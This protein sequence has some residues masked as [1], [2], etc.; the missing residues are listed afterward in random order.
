[1]SPFTTLLC[2]RKSHALFRFFACG[3]GIL[4]LES[5]P[6]SV[7]ARPNPITSYTRLWAEWDVVPNTQ[8]APRS[9]DPSASQDRS[10][11]IFKL[12]PVVP[13]RINDDWTVLTR[14][15]FRFVSLPQADPVLGVSPAGLPAVLGFD[16]KNQA[17]LSDVSPTA[18]LVPNLGSDWTVGLGAS[19]VF[20][21]GDGTVD[22]GKVSAGPAFLAFYHRGPWIVGA[23]MR[24][25]WSFAGDPERDDVN[26]LV[27]RGLL[28][29]QLNRSW[30]LISSPIITSDWTQ[31]EG[32]GWIVP[33][34]GGLG[35][36]FRL[37]GQPMQVSLEGYYNAVKP[38]FAGEEL[39]GDW[40]IRTQ[41]QVLFPN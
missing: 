17:G 35:Y 18:F 41:W 33:V 28:R 5:V 10:L 30:Y 7:K 39:L 36:S 15:I 31:P 12:Q 24:N 29:Y 23:R 9:I 2:R 8:W 14:T 1:M 34:G 16:Q 4:C 6:F 25:I 19:I 27:V 37:G 40:T 26:T 21:T 22:S 3:L 11:Q 32:K 38:Q 20:P 13:F